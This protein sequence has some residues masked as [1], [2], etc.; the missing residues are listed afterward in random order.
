M[1]G[2]ILRGGDVVRLCHLSSTG[3][4]THEAVATRVDFEGNG[5]KML[6][7]AAAGEVRTVL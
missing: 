2:G 5:R 4:L 7:E 6:G 3:F 1:E